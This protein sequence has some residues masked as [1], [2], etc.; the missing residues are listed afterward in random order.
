M[1]W[2]REPYWPAFKAADQ[3]S[4]ALGSARWGVGTDQSPR[5]LAL[6]GWCHTGDAQGSVMVVWMRPCV[7]R[8]TGSA[9]HGTGA[10]V[11]E[12]G[13]LC[14]HYTCTQRRDSPTPVS[15]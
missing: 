12:R 3:M 11:R 13:P 6:A 2:G 15:L 10:Y 7:P 8:D 14:W 4:W 5:A 9:L 1:D